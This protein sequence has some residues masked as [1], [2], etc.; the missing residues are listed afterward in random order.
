MSDPSKMLKKLHIFMVLWFFG[1]M[2]FSVYMENWMVLLWQLL[3]FAFF[4]LY[5]YEYRYAG[6]MFADFDGMI[7]EGIE[8][9]GRSAEVRRAIVIEH[10][11]LL[12]KYQVQEELLQSL[13]KDNWVLRMGVLDYGGRLC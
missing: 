8:I 6:K 2:C 13:Q 1:S 10:L 4:G 5:F 3:C 12:R 7:K 9:M 11:K